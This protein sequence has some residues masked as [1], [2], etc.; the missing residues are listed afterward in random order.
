MKRF[1]LKLAS[2]LSGTVAVCCLAVWATSFAADPTKPQFAFGERVNH[3]AEVAA[4]K[5]GLIVCDAVAN[6]EGFRVVDRNALQGLKVRG[7]KAWS[8]PGLNYRRI[9]FGD[10]APIWAF[11]LS[12]LVPSLAM[13][14]L[15]GCGAWRLRTLGRARAEGIVT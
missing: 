5:G 11:R 4:A 3:R 13:V 9:D 8:L 15:A 14:G 2:L 12:L 10:G 6:L 1:F 7:E